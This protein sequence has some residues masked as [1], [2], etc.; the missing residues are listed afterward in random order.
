MVPGLT[1]C[2]C[3]MACEEVK[4][5]G[6]GNHSIQKGSFLSTPCFQSEV[7]AL[8][9]CPS[10]LQGALPVPAR[11]RCPGA[12]KRQNRGQPGTLGIPRGSPAGSAGLGGLEKR[13]HAPR[14]S[15]EHYS[16]PGLPVATAA[17]A[18]SA[19]AGPPRPLL[20]PAL[21]LP[22]PFPPVVRDR[23]GA[24]PGSRPLALV[25]PVSFPRWSL[26]SPYLAPP[27]RLLRPEPGLLPCNPAD[28]Q[29]SRPWEPIAN[30]ENPGP[31]TLKGRGRTGSH[32]LP[33]TGMYCPQVRTLPTTHTR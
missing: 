1:C 19:S 25:L 2:C 3:F 18:S 17:T 23:R 6:P 22:A 21:L 12:G 8:F 26:A 5:P 29:R 31:E 9:P 14:A 11:P 7:H 4:A 28:G 32:F 30:L 10:P 15:P 16:A 27:P 20:P 33:L 13:A 24:W